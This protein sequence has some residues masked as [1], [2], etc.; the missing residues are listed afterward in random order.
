MVPGMPASGG[1]NGLKEG[2][3]IPSRQVKGTKSDESP[4]AKKTDQLAIAALDDIEAFWREK[5]PKYFKQA[6]SFKPVGTLYS[7][8]ARDPEAIA[9]GRDAYR[10]PNAMYCPREDAIAWDRGVLMPLL[11]N[12]FPPIAIVVVFAHEYGHRIQH[13]AN[14]IKDSDPSIVFEQQ[15]DCFAGFFIRYVVDGRAKHFRLN[16]SNGL[17]TILASMLALRDDPKMATESDYKDQEHGSGFD[18][19]SAFR[20]GFADGAD[21]CS[22]IDEKEIDKRRNG[23]PIVPDPQ[24]G[25]DNI[26]INRSILET[27]AIPSI[28][29]FFQ[30]MLPT[31]PK[32]TY[33]GV[34]KNCPNQKVASD[35]QKAPPALYCEATNTVSLD[36]PAL[37]K[38]GVPTEEGGVPL[39][40][41]GDTAAL[42][43]IASRFGL[44]YLKHQGQP[45]T[46][47]GAGLAGACLSGAWL[48]SIVG[49]YG[50]D[51]AHKPIILTPG[52]LDKPTSELLQHGYIAQD[53]NGQAAPSALTRWNA[54]RVGV[55]G[56]SKVCAQQYP[57]L[58]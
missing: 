55:L 32:V 8:D 18:R 3:P 12:E 27:K 35:P 53:L 41:T 2:V 11:D 6:A 33:D 50:V 36:V 13:L 23:L 57:P 28:Q 10:E 54:F 38:I 21:A 58:P 26:P 37:A 51:A 42:A 39:K 48:R 19:V 45:T 14:L 1:P 34:D 5:L 16:S 25:Q 20:M 49:R 7:Y 30:E 46:G 52:D 44:A 17:N 31:M 29:Q 40:I 4:E 9:C 56:P 22:K 43:I 24:I 47:L 15:A